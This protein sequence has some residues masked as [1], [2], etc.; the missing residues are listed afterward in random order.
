MQN[1]EDLDVILSYIKND[2]FK[3]IKILASNTGEKD[4]FEQ[5]KKYYDI[6]DNKFLHYVY[7]IH[8][9]NLTTYLNDENVLQLFVNWL[10]EY[11]LPYSKKKSVDKM[12]NECCSTYIYLSE[13]PI[14]SQILMKCYDTDVIDVVFDNIDNSEILNVIN[15]NLVFDE[16][17]QQ[18]DEYI[19]KKLNDYSTNENFKYFHLKNYFQKKIFE[20]QTNS[21]AL[22]NKKK[23][24]KVND[25][26]ENYKKA[27]MIISILNCGYSI[28]DL[29]LLSKNSN[30]LKK[31]YYSLKEC[32]IRENDKITIH[33]E[34][35]RLLYENIDDENK[36]F[37]I[38]NVSDSTF[39]S[40]IYYF[41]YVEV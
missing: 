16:K 14:L 11:K 21:Q 26:H 23:N 10:D 41:R 39:R 4:V 38:D 18:R 5:I 7:L 37:F 15:N 40:I 3:H 35:I 17:L 36:E 2:K 34:F 30:E 9:H 13:N 1:S 24:P 32:K 19:F 12:I 27:Q 6:F 33:S 20:K 31:F 25:N 8:K 29:N 28:V 22:K